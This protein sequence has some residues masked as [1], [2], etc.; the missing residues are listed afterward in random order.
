M[1]PLT[2]A[3]IGAVRALDGVC[4]WPSFGFHV[5]ATQFG[6]P[7]LNQLAERYARTTRSAAFSG[8]GAP[9]TGAE[10]SRHT[11]EKLLGINP[12]GG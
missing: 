2:P 12:D 5:I 11:L 1:P 4:A 9:G 3:A 8:V 6:V 10:V 7:A